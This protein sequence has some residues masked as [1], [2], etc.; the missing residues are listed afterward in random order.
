MPAERVLTTRELNRSLLAR[1]LLLERVSLPAIEVVE[2]LVGMQ[3]Q[4]PMDP[5]VG[6]WSR[7]DGFRPDELSGLIEERKAVRVVALMRTTIH[8]VSARDALTIRALVDPVA[9]RAWGHS[10]F[11]KSIADADVDE[12]VAA[13]V[14]ILAERPHVPT[15]L[16]RR[17][18]ERWPDADAQS[19]GYAVRFLV[20]LVQPPPRG[21]WG[22]K[23]PAAVQ[24]LET[25]L[26]RPLAASPSLDELILRYLAAFGPATAAD[27]ATWSWLTGIREVLDRLRLRLVT[28]RDERGRELFDVPDAPFPDP[29][30]PAPVRFLP[31][32]DNIVLSHDDRTRVIDRKL[33]EPIWLRG[34]ILVD[35]FV[36]GTWR[37]DQK[38]RES[39]LRIGL[40]DSLTPSDRADVEAEGERLRTFLAPDATSR[41]LQVGQV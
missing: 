10:P 23:G 37:H 35:G 9:R 8:L 27:V 14:A 4:E 21:L 25:W 3:A 34:S 7:I 22:R 29:E 41:A 17:L 12:V 5:Y 19:L 33:T 30:T 20:P 18:R 38:G 31:E 13:G 24:T 16:G 26:G 15:E 6:L 40:F 28:Y 39:T 11:P 2:R 32:Y 36:R 1:Q